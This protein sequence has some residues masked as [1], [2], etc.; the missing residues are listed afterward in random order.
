MKI[1]PE[2]AVS[3]SKKIFMNVIYELVK[4]HSKLQADIRRA[5]FCQN[6]ITLFHKQELNLCHIV[7]PEINVMRE[8]I[9][10]EHPEF[11]YMVDHIQKTV[12]S[13]EK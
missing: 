4:L 9:S 10:N 8:F 7:Y 1:S 13:E 12:E 11:N 2:A 5:T 3:M 6:D